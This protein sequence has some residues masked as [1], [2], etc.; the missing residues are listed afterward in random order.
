MK[1]TVARQTWQPRFWVKREIRAYKRNH[2]EESHTVF[3]NSKMTIKNKKSEGD[4]CI[5]LV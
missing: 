2:L 5:Q 3:N 1:D 4:N